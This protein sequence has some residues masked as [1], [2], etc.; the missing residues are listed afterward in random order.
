MSR[1]VAFGCSYT[2]GQGLEDCPW[3][4]DTPSELA[5]P[6]KLSERLTL[7]CVNQGR[8]GRSNKEILL[9]ILNADLTTTDT[10]IILWTYTH[11][12][13]IFTDEFYENSYR[14]NKIGSHAIKRYGPGMDKLTGRNE[15]ADLLKLH[16]ELDILADSCLSIRHAD[17]YL[18]SLG[19]T[20][21]HF[22]VE[23]IISPDF[24]KLD[25]VNYVGFNPYKG[26]DESG[27][28]LHP[29]PR[30]QQLIADIMYDTINQK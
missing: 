6:A 30:T 10:V 20:H 21:Y 27:D 7:E 2:W 26:I 5:W 17:L 1:L 11:R 9:S 23:E 22:S 24:L 29:G 12:Y 28:G 8:P 13:G 25:A 19:I 4:S 15:Y 16:P 18:K 14:F 3:G